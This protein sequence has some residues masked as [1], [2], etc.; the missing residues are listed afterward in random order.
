MQLVIVE[1]PAK[2]RTIEKYLGKDYT[3][4]A[5]FGHVRDLPTKKIGIDVHHNFEPVYEVTGR[6]D[7]LKKI[8]AAAK[9][10]AKIVLAT[11]LDREGEAIAWH[12]RELLEAPESK[13]ERVVF[14]EIT[15][16]AIK[17]AFT[18]PRKLNLNLV[19]AQVARRVLDRLVGYKLSPLLWQKVRAGLSA[20]RVQSVAVRLMVDRER[21]IEEFKKVEYW[22][23]KASLKPKD[24]RE[25]MAVLSECDDKALDNLAVKNEAQAKKIEK[26]LQNAQFIVK[27]INEK[28]SVRYPAPPFATST[29][30]M[31]AARKLGYSA[32][33][34][35][36]LAQMLYED[37]HI[38]YMRT[39]STVMSAS[40][41]NAAR[42]EI[43]KQFGPNYL[44]AS[45]R[46]YKTKAKGAQEAH[47]AI[48]PTHFNN[49]RVNVEPAARKLYELIWKRAMASQMAEA[50]VKITEIK[51]AAGCYGFL[52][53]G[54]TVEFPG[55]LKLY[56]EDLDE[57]TPQD[58]LIAGELLPQ[59]HSGE[60]LELLKLLVEQ[61]FT[62]PLPRY[63]EAMLVKALE[64]AGIGRPSTYAPT[65]STI[66]ERGYV[67]LLE[68]RLYPTEI[69]IIV[70][71]LLKEHFADI[72]DLNFTA[73]MEGNLD[74][75]A[76]GSR[77]WVEVVKD[78][79]G[80]FAKN[81]REKS[82]EIKKEDLVE[83]T[84][85]KCPKCGQGERVI[86]VGRY[87]KFYTCSRY[88]ECDYAEKVVPNGGK[89]AEPKKVVG[90]CPDC[91]GELVERRGR[92]GQFVGCGNYPKCKYIV[93]P[94]V[95][96]VAK[97][98]DCGGNVI[99]KRTKRGKIFYGCA[100]YPKCKYATWEKPGESVKSKK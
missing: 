64:K 82:K 22:A 41:I 74:K 86:K 37:G 17:N 29:L 33:R 99:E 79:Y 73:E 61:K 31:E 83:E 36:M 20:G 100:N 84:D 58:A 54:E 1:S 39:D 45:P 75:V 94:P 55:F 6:P 24:D 49:I 27:E 30:Q 43:K 13:T 19:D 77:K 47:E 92:Y 85:Q 18:H 9:K 44:P 66:Q 12:L 57:D 56:F 15:E 28:P 14:H 89:K 32:K 25:F 35:M 80:P 10:A 87:G 76:E 11:D 38:T 26:E 40:A 50:K 88:P 91:G 34:T 93:V 8:T 98:L 46:I 97:C 96:I 52:A 62:E 42:T 63:T 95:K 5:S 60:L 4:L 90:K 21:E 23:I 72:V 78:F 16:G 7:V 65:L 48:R 69:G 51:I 2:A 71:D 67:E 70:T 53:K 68:K 3:V 59:V 81:L